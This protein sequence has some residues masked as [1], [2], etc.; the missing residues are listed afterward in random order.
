V[1]IESNIDKY[2]ELKLRLLNGTHT[3]SC[4]LAFLS[5]YETV[6]EAMDSELI[7]SL[8]ASLMQND[9]APSIPYKID[10]AVARKFG[11]QVLDRFRN[12]HIRHLWINITM[13]YSSKMKTRCIPVLL[14]HYETNNTVPEL[15]ALGFAGYL[16]FMK[17]VSEKN[18]QYFGKLQG[19]DYLIQ[20]DQ[21]GVFYRRWKTLSTNALV[22]EVLRDDAF[23]G[24]DLHSLPG[25]QQAITDKLNLMISNGTRETI[26]TVHSKK[27]FAA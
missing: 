10:A 22:E 15:F 11:N 14:K 24:A 13:Q 6:K 3:L 21:A 27:V 26:E 9:I 18:G 12:P 2:R 5:G 23:W 1:I 20:D 4:G 8:I 16:Y 19:K 25:F 7:S 17:A